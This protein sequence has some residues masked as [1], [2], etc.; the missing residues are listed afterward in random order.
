L[1]LTTCQSTKSPAG[2]NPQERSAEKV[3]PLLDDSHLEP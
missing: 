2:V 3:K 1:R